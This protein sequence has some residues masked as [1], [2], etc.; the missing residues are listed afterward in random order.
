MHEQSRFASID[1][2]VFQGAQKEFTG[3][4]ENSKEPQ[5]KLLLKDRSKLPAGYEWEE[6]GREFSYKG[7]FYDIVSLK[8]TQNGWE[9][10][11]VSDEAETEIVNNQNKAS[12]LEKEA[13]ATSKSSSKFKIKISKLVYDHVAPVATVHIFSN[14]KSR[15]SFFINHMPNPFSTIFTPPPEAV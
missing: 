6:A 11:A 15:I 2:G 4:T 10:T 7:Q 3:T 9:L 13:S 8:H 14:K 1:A 5:V 12:N